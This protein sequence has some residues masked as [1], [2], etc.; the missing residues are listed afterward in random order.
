MM[1][2][3]VHDLLLATRPV[4]APVTP[5]MQPAKATNDSASD[6]VKMTPFLV[7]SSK[8]KPPEGDQILSRQAFAAALRKRYPGASVPGQDPYQIGDGLPNYARLR[9]ENEQ[10]NAQ[11]ASWNEFA[12]LLEH[13]GSHANAVRIKKEI[14]TIDSGTYKDPLIDAMDRSANGG[15]R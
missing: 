3:H 12:D 14:R 10:R 2:P 15:R 13:T 11:K 6:A 5:V 9:Y 4:Y 8:L 7:L 1:S